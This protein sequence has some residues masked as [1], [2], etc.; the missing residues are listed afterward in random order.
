MGVS[1]KVAVR[2]RQVEA[3]AVASA[4]RGTTV[5]DAELLGIKAHDLS[6]LLGEVNAGFD[7]RSFTRL[8]KAMDLPK[9]ELAELVQI[10]PRTLTRRQVEGKLHPNESERLLRAARLFQKAIELFEGDAAAARTWLTTPNRALKDKRP[11][12]LARTELGA[13][14]VENLIGRLE[15]GVFT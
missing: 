14:E 12:D 4:E 7:F 15:H 6:S 3:K 5:S 8:Q 13:R 10:K 1:R 9:Y 11:L 2:D